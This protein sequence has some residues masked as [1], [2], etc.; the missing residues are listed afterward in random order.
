MAI[1]LACFMSTGLALATAAL[2]FHVV[3]STTDHLAGFVASVLAA[4]L[5]VAPSWVPYLLAT[6][7]LFG[8][9]QPRYTP[10]LN[11]AERT[12]LGRGLAAAAAGALG[13]VGAYFLPVTTDPEHWSAVTL[14]GLS[15]AGLATGLTAGALGLAR[16]HAR[17]RFVVEAASGKVRGF[18]IEESDDGR[19][20]L[21]RVS[22]GGDYRAADREESLALD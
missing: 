1:Y 3:S 10:P 21:I 12:Y 11:Q 20:R 2:A 22:A 14:Y 13:L 9:P 5:V 8:W 15:L 6:L 7:R 16:E 17:R 19:R 4:L 18:R